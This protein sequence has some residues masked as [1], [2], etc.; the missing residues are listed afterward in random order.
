M[1]R[2]RNQRRVL[3][4]AFIIIIGALSLLDNLHVFDA[5]EV[6]HFWPMVFVALGGLKI[7]QTRN[8]SGYLVGTALIAVGVI[9]TLQSMGI[10]A[11]R[12][13][14]WWPVL[15]IAGGIVVI[16]R[17]LFGRRLVRDD[18]NL[19]TVVAS[20]SYVDAV[21]VMSGNKTKNVSQ[22]FRG[23]EITAVMGGIEL[24]LRQASIQADA[25]IHVFAMWGGIVIRVPGDWSVV[26]NG[27]PLLG[28]FED[29]S[30]PPASP[31]KR[32]VIEGYAIMGGVE[33][34]N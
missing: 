16:S 22:D 17:G 15:L 7:F 6:L 3:F 9:L 33:I 27:V 2:F 10:V 8:A 29:K 4:G 20:E 1:N 23:G 30:V 18:R 34:K 5:R 25:T 28:G 19:R 14:D 24:D 32:L 26:T 12:W 21:A 13:R 11:F 31:A